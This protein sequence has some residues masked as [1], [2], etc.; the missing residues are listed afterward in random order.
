MAPGTIAPGR[1]SSRHEHAPPGRRLVR[2]TVGEETCA[3][4]SG[5]L[6]VGVSGGRSA[7]RP[8][9]DVP[10]LILLGPVLPQSRVKS[11]MLNSALLNQIFFCT[12][13]RSATKLAAG[14]R[15]RW[16]ARL[17]AMTP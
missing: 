10:L 6:R 7:S 11:D 15:S 3:R 14:R 5:S 9:Q 12:A 4:R 17:T 16:G 8:H 1:P 2:Q 13:P